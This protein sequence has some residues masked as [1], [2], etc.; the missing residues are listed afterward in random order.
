MG[1]E[2]MKMQNNLSFLTLAIFSVFFIAPPAKASLILG[3]AQNFAVLGA[4]T[5]TNTGPTTIYGDL[6]LSP[7]SSITGLGGITITGT[8]HQT[9]AAA[10]Q[11]QSDAQAAYNIL[12]GKSFTTD[13]SGQDLG[14]MT[15]TPGIYFFSSLAQLTGALTLDAQGLSNALF[16]FQIN[17][18]LTTASGSV[19][20]M[21]NGGLNPGVFWKVGSSAT[22]GTSTSF[23]GNIF[24]DQSITLNTAAKILCGRAIALH[25]AVTIDSN[26]I[27]NDCSAF[28]GGT[29]AS[30]YA[31]VGFSGGTSDITDPND[32]SAPATVSLFLLGILGFVYSRKG[33][34]SITS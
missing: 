33:R 14:G 25:A 34:V 31:S 16:V 8:V 21:I 9:D 7:G 23:A 6:G 10:L 19:V 13:L 28:N 2:F 5:V 4:S 12:M 17:S 32:V 26:T 18:S 11:A 15:L 29:S 1:I 30:D 22:L 27:S 20:S 3:S 24:A